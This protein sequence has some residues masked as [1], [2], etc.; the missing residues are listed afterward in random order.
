M[1]NWN[2][3]IMLEIVQAEFTLPSIKQ[4]QSFKHQSHSF[5]SCDSYGYLPSCDKHG[6]IEENQHSLCRWLAEANHS[7]QNPAARAFYHRVLWPDQR[8]SQ[9]KL[10]LECITHRYRATGGDVSCISTY[11]DNEGLVGYAAWFG[12]RYVFWHSC[13]NKTERQ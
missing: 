4:T 9:L 1:N 2:L 12:V 8:R 5:H 3:F 6:G 11:S 10:Q 7:A 13:G